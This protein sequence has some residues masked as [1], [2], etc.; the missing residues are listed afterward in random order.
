MC[1][2]PN[3]AIWHMCLEFHRR[4]EKILFAEFIK[5]SKH[6]YCRTKYSFNVKS[7]TINQITFPPKFILNVPVLFQAAIVR[8]TRSCA[9]YKN[10]KYSITAPMYLQSTGI[11]CPTP[12]PSPKG[13]NKL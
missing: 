13:R 7:M 10:E 8:K 4:L 3:N 12:F 5:S 9:V 1:L 6:N 11:D 2:I